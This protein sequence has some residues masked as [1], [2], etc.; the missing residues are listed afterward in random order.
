MVLKSLA[1]KL[2]GPFCG[3]P[4]NESP[5][6][7]AR[8]FWKLQCDGLIRGI[9]IYIAIISDPHK[10]ATRL[11]TRSLDHGFADLQSTSF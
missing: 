11:P 3:C 4:D 2:G 8:D 7:T 1:C 5:T 6:T 10:R 9:Y